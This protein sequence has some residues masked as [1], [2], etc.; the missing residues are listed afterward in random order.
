MM[1]DVEC[2]S[3]KLGIYFVSLL[4]PEKVAILCPTAELNWW[5]E[6]VFFEL[7]DGHIV[8]LLQAFLSGYDGNL[9]KMPFSHTG[10]NNY[11]INVESHCF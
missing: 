3:L 11:M 5:L 7:N 8:I 6:L 1:I 4:R 10:Q 9:R 2:H